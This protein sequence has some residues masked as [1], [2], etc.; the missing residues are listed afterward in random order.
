MSTLVQLARSV[1]LFGTMVFP[2]KI[3]LREGWIS[4]ICCSERSFRVGYLDISLWDC[5]NLLSKGGS[6]LVVHAA[7]E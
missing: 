3:P 1:D 6:I 7:S 5:S 4:C 2:I